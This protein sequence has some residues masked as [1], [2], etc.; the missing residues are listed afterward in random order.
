MATDPF[1]NASPAQL[2]EVLNANRGG[3]NEA[4]GLRFTAVAPD[5]VVAE[6]DAGPVHAQPYGLVHGGVYASIVE[7]LASTGAALDGRASGRSA[8]GLENATSFLRA[9]RGGRLVGRAVPLQKGRRAQV[10]EVEIR[11]DADRL[12]AKGKVRLL[13]LEPNAAV[14]GEKVEVKG[15]DAGPGPGAG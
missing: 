5:E 8:V 7:S 12:C 15:G 14:A 1:Q 4:L 6:L 11:D 9:S 13:M 2:L 10:W 3:F